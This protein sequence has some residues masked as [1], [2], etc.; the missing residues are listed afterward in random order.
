MVPGGSCAARRGRDEWAECSR[1]RGGVK[2]S[3][4]GQP[5]PRT[6]RPGRPTVRV[7][8]GG[9]AGR[10]RAG[11]APMPH[12][13]PPSAPA[14]RTNISPTISGPDA[15]PATP[16][17]W[18]A[19]PQRSC[20]RAEPER[21][22]SRPSLGCLARASAVSPEPRRPSS[23]SLAHR[24]RAVIPMGATPSALDGPGSLLANRGA[25]QATGLA[26]DGPRLRAVTRAPPPR[27]AG[28][29]RRRL[30]TGKAAGGGQ[31]SAGLTRRRRAAVS[32]RGRRARA[33]GGPRQPV[34]AR[35]PRAVARAT[36][37]TRRTPRRAPARGC[38]A[39]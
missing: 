27:S 21:R 13:V 9:R 37:S 15:R 31:P 34:A 30:G 20:E 12:R 36:S 1:D 16:R 10:G 35:Q 7:A 14:A 25:D 18:L 2:R 5:A 8:T 22:L 33:S 28:L 11:H 29:T 17:L 38:C 19:H 23:G 26:H 32:R 39:R 3:E 4:G 24:P 6:L